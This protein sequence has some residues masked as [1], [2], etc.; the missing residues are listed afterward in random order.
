MVRLAMNRK[1]WIGLINKELKI[2]L[3]LVAI[4]EWGDWIAK[5]MNHSLD[6]L[7]S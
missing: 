1:W 7:L 3:E 6:R 5:N 2:Y 4:F